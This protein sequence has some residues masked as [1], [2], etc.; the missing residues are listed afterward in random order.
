MTRLTNLM[1]ALLWFTCLIGSSYAMAEVVGADQWVP[2]SEVYVH[3]DKLKIV[4]IL[5]NG[6]EKTITKISAGVVTFTFVDGSAKVTFRHNSNGVSGTL[7]NESGFPIS[8]LITDPQNKKFHFRP[9]LSHERLQTIEF[10]GHSPTAG[11]TLRMVDTRL[12]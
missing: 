9:S 2:L 10:P 7:H 3:P 4:K 11:L 1:I 8:Y 5:A 6:Q 12:L